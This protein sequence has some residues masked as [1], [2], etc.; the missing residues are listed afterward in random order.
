M[1]MAKSKDPGK[2]KSLLDSMRAPLSP[3]PEPLQYRVLSWLFG[4]FTRYFR[5]NRLR[6]VRITEDEVTLAVSDRKALRNHVGSIHAAAINLACEYASGLLL[7]QYAPVDKIVVVKSMHLD[8]HKP[9]SGSVLAT[10]SFPG[11]QLAAM[12]AEEKGNVRIPVA[13]VDSLGV[14]PAS[15][16]MDMAWFKR[17]K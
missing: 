13:V 3:L 15:G 17:R 11:K 8:I 10:A 6:I 7:G 4:R 9:V 16:Y 1:L 14:T 2:P 12:L 5:T